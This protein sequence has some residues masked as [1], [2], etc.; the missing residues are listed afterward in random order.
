MYEMKFHCTAPP[1]T[2][3]QIIAHPSDPVNKAIKNCYYDATQVYI[4]VLD[5]RNYK[6][7]RKE[8]Y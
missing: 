4:S 2:D 3:Y 5:Y 7:H 6:A 1:N 8:L